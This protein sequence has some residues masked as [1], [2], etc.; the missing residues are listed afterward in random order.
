MT[1][2]RW[3]ECNGILEQRAAVL[4][5]MRATAGN[6]TQAARMLGISRRY[7]HKV[8]PSVLDE[9]SVHTI[10]VLHG[11]NGVN[12]MEGGEVSSHHSG[13]GPV[14]NDSPLTY[15]QPGP[16]LAPV[17]AAAIQTEDLVLLKVESFPRDLKEWLENRAVSRKHRLREKQASIGRTL[18]EIVRAAKQREEQGE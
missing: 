14:S 6:V 4:G 18:A 3:R 16:T 12:R 1:V 8:I 13:V 5:A 10:H 11:V 9:K 15:G 7:L 2:T 17:N